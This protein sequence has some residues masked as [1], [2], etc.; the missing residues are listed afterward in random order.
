MSVEATAAMW[1]RR[2]LTSTEKVVAVRL[3][4]HA[5]PDGGRAYPSVGRLAKDCG[6]TDRAV[7][8]V[9]HR[10][11][12]K[13]VI[14]RIGVHPKWRTMQYQVILTPNEVHPEQGSPPNDVPVEGEPDDARGRTTD[15][16]T[17]NEPSGTVRPSDDEIEA[18]ADRR[19]AEAV[20][21]GKV[22]TSKRRYR[23]SIV[24][25]LRDEG[26]TS[27]DRPQ[28]PKPAGPSVEDT[29]AESEARA[30]IEPAAPPMEKLRA[31]LRGGA[32]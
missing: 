13:G 10:L 26:W 12:D 27:D 6:L 20:A 9:L 24:A 15:T 11:I 19:L 22:R 8:K 25:N 1:A 2:D 3:A 23:R 32:S 17:V 30:A 14:V 28:P 5:N 18:E 16:Q 7:Q 31:A 4:D 29:L 21:A